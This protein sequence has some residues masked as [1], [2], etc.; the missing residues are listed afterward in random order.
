[1]IEKTH[2]N[3]GMESVLGLTTAAVVGVILNLTLFLG[4]D[5]IFP[6]GVSLSHLDYFSLSWV[7]VS[8]LLL[9]KSKI[10][11][12]Y[13]ILLSLAAGLIQYLILRAF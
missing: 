4:K 1:M 10:N 8:L 13:L 12:V 6:G 7:F 9:L 3:R 2:G 11:V 5:V